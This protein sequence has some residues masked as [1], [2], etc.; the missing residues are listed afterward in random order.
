MA[1][2]CAACL[3][4][5]QPED[6]IR[7]TDGRPSHLDCRRPT[8]LTPEERV[9]L[10]RYCADHAVAKCPTCSLGYRVDQLA[11]DVFRGTSNLCPRCRC[12][13]TSE[14]RAHLYGC[15]ML[16][17]AVR[18][19]ARTAREVAQR[20]VKRSGELTD[21]ADVLMR[22][23]EAALKA[24]RLAM[25]LPRHG[26]A[27]PARSD[28]RLLPM[29]LLVG[30]Y[31]VEATGVWEV[32]GPPFTSNGGKTVHARVRRV[33]NPDTHGIRSWNVDERIIVRRAG[34]AV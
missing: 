31:I 23:L 25:L 4:P 9:T 34:P 10:F 15:A 16:P 8:I 33:A 27:L 13:L 21:M 14:V 30:D 24:L 6:A 7:F 22:E 26:G 18:D 20:L 2:H 19:R 29:Q 1:L 12:D 32:V 5:M 11:A 3:K 28:V 17:A